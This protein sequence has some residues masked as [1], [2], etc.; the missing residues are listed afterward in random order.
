VEAVR[1]AIYRLGDRLSRTP[2]GAFIALISLLAL[3]RSGVW[4]LPPRVELLQ[5]NLRSFPNPL[6]WSESTSYGLRS[7][8]LFFRVDTTQ[9]SMIFNAAA[10]VCCIGLCITFLALRFRG[11][12]F[13]LMVMTVILGPITTVILGNIG[14]NDMLLLTGSVLVACSVP[15][16]HWHWL[17]VVGACLMLSANP[18]QAVI[19]AGLLLVASMTVRLAAYRKSAVLALA[20]CSVGLLFLHERSVSAGT[21]SRIGSFLGNLKPSMEIFLTGAPLVIY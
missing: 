7:L 4:F 10:S 8:L 2:A 20:I 9:E 16:R 17:T 19:A 15:S 18:E 13:R 21:T 6:P 11:P 14:R 3:F 1:Q 12:S 5:E